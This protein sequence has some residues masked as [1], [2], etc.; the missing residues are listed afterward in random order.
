M[1][2]RRRGSASGE[3]QSLLGAATRRCSQLLPLPLTGGHDAVGVAAQDDEQ[4]QVE[5]RADEGAC[6][7]EE[8]SP[9]ERVLRWQVLE[10]GA[11]RVQAW[12]VG[13]G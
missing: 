13:A 5:D 4:E 12:F 11:D 2:E 1:V 3:R 8:R 6:K 10:A 7:R 9:R